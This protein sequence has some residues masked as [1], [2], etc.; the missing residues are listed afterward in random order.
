MRRIITPFFI[1][2]ELDRYRQIVQILIK[3][4]F[5]SYLDR[6]RIWEHTNIEKRLLHRQAAPVIEPSFAERLRLALSELG[7]TFIKLGQ[8]LATRP[9]LIPADI[10]NELEK[11]EDRVNFL[12]FE[13]IKSAIES[14]LG[15]P[16]QEI[17]TSIEEKPVA[18]ASIAQVHRAIFNR[19]TVAVKVQRPNIKNVMETDL[20]IM[21]AIAKLLEQYL[22][23]TE[24]LNPVGL[25]NEF[26]AD[27]SRELDFC[28]ETQNIKHYALNFQDY[29]WIKVPIVFD[30]M[31]TKKIITMEFLDGVM[32]SNLDRLSEEGYN[33]QEIAEHGVDILLKSILEYGFFHADP[34]AGNMF[35]LPGNVLGLIDYGMM[36][37]VST[38]TK[39]R[40][41]RLI[42][43]I[44]DRDEKRLARVLDELMESEFLV[45]PDDLEEGVAM[46]LQEYT[47]SSNEFELG[48]LLFGLVRLANSYN[49][50]FP[51]YLLWLTKTISSIEAI[52]NKL[53]AH[54]NL[55]E[56]SKPYAQELLKGQ[57]TS[58]NQIRHSY[59]WKANTMEVLEDLPYDIGV[60]LRRLTT[61]KAQLQIRPVG[62]EEGRRIALNITNRI[63]LIFLTGILFLV[64]ALL[65]VSDVPPFV[66]DI[67]LLGVIGFAVSII[68]SLALVISILAERK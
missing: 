40:L 33:L 61:G 67:P 23:G 12:P 44:R 59:F 19:M 38:R 22:P 41:I 30:Q 25:V 2:R 18:A 20:E 16:V 35:I 43:A 10:I 32:I 5:G 11:L 42:T 51:K 39:Y 17:F 58:F 26:A 27:I 55:L 3:Y 60:L 1:I 65:V 34:H 50:P 54:V 8:T 63:A 6:I 53:G 9:D 13:V 21:L 31:S 48:P 46:I 4:G 68:L 24:L 49:V 37:T 66:G 15:R 64:S 62:L 28:Q 45:A 7:P 47:V 14:E 56:A 57:V 29:P 52:S 36:G